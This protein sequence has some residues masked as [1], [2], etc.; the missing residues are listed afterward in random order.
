MTKREIFGDW[1]L[2]V[3]GPLRESFLLAWMLIF[4]VLGLGD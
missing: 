2:Q 3:I 4:Q 1:L